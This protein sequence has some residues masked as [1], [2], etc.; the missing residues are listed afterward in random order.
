MHGVSNS[1]EYF[2]VGYSRIGHDSV[3][4]NWPITQPGN[5][6]TDET[7]VAIFDNTGDFSREQDYW[8]RSV[9][10]AVRTSDTVHQ[11][12]RVVQ[13]LSEN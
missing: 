9:G 12:H 8:N 10:S 11:V 13:P 6:G 7:K 2:D 5:C 4:R 1:D 3:D